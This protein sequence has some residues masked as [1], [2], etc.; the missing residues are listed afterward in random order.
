MIHFYKIRKPL[1]GKQPLQFITYSSVKQDLGLPWW[2]MHTVWWNSMHSGKYIPASSGEPTQGNRG[3][4]WQECV[5]SKCIWFW[6]QCVLSTGMHPPFSPCVL[7]T[8]MHPPF[9]SCV[10]STGIF[11]P[12][13]SSSRSRHTETT[14]WS[15]APKT[16]LSAKFGI[17][18]A[19]PS[20]SDAATLR[21]R[22]Q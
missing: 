9:S 15:I 18:S 14:E 10:W 19:W 8:G 7:S 20:Q 13:A 21:I 12:F 11:T 2:F 22:V 1:I 6:I 5:G 17:C 4:H 3:E 16:T